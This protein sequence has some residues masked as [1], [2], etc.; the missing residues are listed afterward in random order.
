M[1]KAVECLGL[2]LLPKLRHPRI[3]QGNSWI[4]RDVSTFYETLGQ[5]FTRTAH[6]FEE[7]LLGGVYGHGGRDRQEIL[8]IKS[9][10]SMVHFHL[11][12]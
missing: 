12:A 3:I 4:S 11:I 5:I 8:F 10:C 9:N 6:Y 2:S 1:G 7:V